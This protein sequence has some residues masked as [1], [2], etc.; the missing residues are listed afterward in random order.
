MRN[1]LEVAKREP[2]SSLDQ[3]PPDARFSVIFYNLEARSSPTP[4]GS[5]AMP[6]TSANKRE[7]R[8]SYALSSPTAAPTT[9]R[10]SA[11]RWR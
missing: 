11:R 2:L 4:T 7:C 1:S 8:T 3:L 6:A 10:P 5:R 9:C